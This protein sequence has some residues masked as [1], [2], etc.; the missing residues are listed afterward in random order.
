MMFFMSIWMMLW[1]ITFDDILIFSKKMVD[2][3]C[4][5]HIV[6]E[7]LREV[8]IYAKLG[9]CGFHQSKVECLGYIISRNGI[10]MDLRK[11]QTIVD[12]ATPTSIQDVQCF[13]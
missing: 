6:L 7:K 2:H 10:H 11:V 4:H 12:W 5:V 13:F 8:G 9:K 1:S 3:E